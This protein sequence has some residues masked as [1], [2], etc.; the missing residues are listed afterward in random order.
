M[1]CGPFTNDVGAIQIL[2]ANTRGEAIALFERDP[3]IRDKYYSAYDVY[4]LHEANEANHWLMSIEQ[5]QK[6]LKA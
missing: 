3:F 4:E 5:T 2:R 1:I 6:N